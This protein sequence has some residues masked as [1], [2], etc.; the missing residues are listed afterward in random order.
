VRVHVRQALPRGLSYLVAILNMF[1]YMQLLP[2]FNMYLAANK[3][4][5]F[6]RIFFIADENFF[7]CSQS[8]SA[9]PAVALPL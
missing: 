8:I 9:F 3:R 4:T 5:Q 7:S 2:T 1:Q 6:E